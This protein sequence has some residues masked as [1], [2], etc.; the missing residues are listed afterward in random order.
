MIE[1][2][3]RAALRQKLL[4]MS[5]A[6]LWIGVGIFSVMNLP[7]DSFPDVSNVQVQ[8]I[9][10]P[11][12]MPT[13][14]IETL[15]TFPIENSLN[16]LPH[17]QQVRSNSSFGLSVVTAIFDDSTD[18]Y[19][20]RNV[21]QQR[22]STLQLAPEVPKPALGPVISTFSNVLNYYLTSP[23]R[24]LTEL[25]TI[26]D[27]DIAL[28]LRAVHGVANVVSYGGYEKEYQVYLRPAALR[29]YG[30]SVKK[31]ADAI[32]ANNENAGGKFI[33]KAGEEVIIRGVGRISSI[34]DIQDIVLKSVNG[35]PVKVSQV[36]DVTIGAAFRR[37][38]SSVDGNEEAVTAMV[39]ARKGANSKEVVEKI[40]EKLKQI[41]AD[42]PE[43]VKIHVYYDQSNLV[44][45]TIDTVKEVLTISSGLVIAVLFALLLNIRSSLIVAVIIPM[46]L[47]FSF[48][49][50]KQTGL[51]ANIMTLGAVD[52]GVIVDAGVVM[53]E[54]IFRRLSENNEHGGKA[55]KSAI[56]E[57][58]ALEVG[59]PIVF[60]ITIIIAVFIPLFA[61]T[62]IEGRMFHPLALTYIFA[63]VGAL[64]V[65]LLFIPLLCRYCMR[66]NVIER[67]HPVLEQLRKALHPVLIQSFKRPFVVT[68]IASIA[69]LVSL[70]IVPWLGSEF[71][72]SLD[73]GS[74]LLR[75]K[76]APSV[77]LEESRRI[78]SHLETILKSFKQV[79]VVC[80]RI[81]RS[82]QASDLEGV[83]NADIFIGLK[84]KNEWHES[85]EEL[86]NAMANEM[87]KVPGLKYSFSQ[88]IS[89]MIDD[90][91]SGI[92]ADVGIKIFGKDVETLDAIASKIEAIAKT[93]N[94]SSDLQREHIL[95][96]PVLT[97]K[98]KRQNIARYGLNVKDVLD[99]VRIAIA[100]QIVSEVIE[101]PKHFGLMVR[102]PLKDR[103][104]VKDIGDIMVDTASGAQVPLREVVD[105]KIDKGMVMIN[106]EEG[107]RRTAVLVNVRGRDLGSFVEELQKKVASQI[108]LPKGIRIVWGGQFENQQRAMQRLTIV[109]PI[110]LLLIF[111]L[112][113]ASL[114]SLRNSAL[115]MLNVPFSLI[116][117][118]IALFVSH[119]VLSVPAVIG[120]I[121]L[122]GV[123]VQNGVIL[124]TY[125]MQQEK[126]GLTA[127][128]AAE[129]GAEVRL[130]P[131]LMTAL[132]AIVGFT[133]LLL[134]QGTGAEVQR[135]LATVVTGGL[136]TATPFTLLL[137][138]TLYVVFN[139]RRSNNRSTK[140]DDA[141]Q[142]LSAENSSAEENSGAGQDLTHSM[143]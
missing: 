122:F 110:V 64:L 11:E 82:G 62:G 50:M 127:Q 100:G 63:L 104:D 70:A 49:L 135:P 131:V 83:D 120:F 91:V 143:H 61:L 118:I 36:A 58:A 73:E 97:I 106:R 37:G 107:E 74:I 92:R 30:L 60:S 19:W 25:R 18:V 124:V 76:L 7:V 3:I 123:A 141:E 119:Q 29:G 68:G 101:T 114:G 133:P 140:S 79:D 125:I 9:T 33:V 28:S 45:H 81:G 13:E 56:I 14:E 121:A 94:G 48:I 59:K 128:Q 86:V 57:Q 95:G 99:I 98:L 21:V 85:K 108:E 65:S 31:V 90:L 20:A 52:F 93:V 44:D 38:A 47:L 109:V 117:G 15:V 89:D 130:R 23:N 6:F 35:T 26:Q 5:A 87:S 78:T 105:M 126:E 136:L 112:L 24:S 115:V 54:N 129:S 4:F 8:I 139:R 75:I 43:D 67:E 137:L 27:W 39:F 102:Y 10:E 80:A 17:I 16:G 42:L 34:E 96:L 53:V 142:D 138:P 41:Q 134:S 22:L 51:S 72:P 116:G 84:P 132:V 111:I 69:L 12:T 2:L 46:S 103:D 113:Y 1:H 40:L 55:T 66:D 88:P 32:A 77:A 71:V